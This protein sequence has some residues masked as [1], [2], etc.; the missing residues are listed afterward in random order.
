MQTLIELAAAL[1]AGR[2]TSRVLVEQ[3]LDRIQD[4]VGEGSR[5]FVSVQADAARAQADASDALRRYGRAAGPFAGIPISVK[6]L[7]DV[8]GQVTAAGSVVLSDAP[9]ATAQKFP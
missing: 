5:V 1:D 3:C 2:T 6:D 9:P 8:A 4:P 7:F